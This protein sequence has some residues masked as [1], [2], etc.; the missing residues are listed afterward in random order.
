MAKNSARCL[1]LKGSWS[2]QM[3]CFL[4]RLWEIF[5]DEPPKK[6]PPE[7]LFR[8]SLARD[9]SSFDLQT[10]IT[11][12]ITVDGPSFQGAQNLKHFSPN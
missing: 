8:L 2:P 4:D 1:S 11:T 5:Y 9:P 12:D 3:G 7:T 10:D 6:L